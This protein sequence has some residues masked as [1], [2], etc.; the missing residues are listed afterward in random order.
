MFTWN[1]LYGT[2][3]KRLQ[4][5]GAVANTVQTFDDG[6]S[7]TLDDF[8]NPVSAMESP[9]YVPS[10]PIMSGGYVTTQSTPMNSG[11]GGSMQASSSFWDSSNGMTALLQSIIAAKQTYD[12]NQIN[13]ELAKQGKAPLSASQ[14]QSLVPQV[15]VGVATDTQRMAL[16]G[17]GILAAA[18][19]VPKLLK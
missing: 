10:V 1:P 18:L 3:V 6:S 5:L 4:G 12:V 13:L 7:I 2:A 14:M 15:R 16:I 11:T 17:V 9:Q 19:I 8:G